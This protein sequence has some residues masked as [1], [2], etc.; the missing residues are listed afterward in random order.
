[1]KKLLPGQ[2]RFVVRQ[3]NKLFR[4]YDV[5]RASYP[6]QTDELGVV[7]QDV[8]EAEAQ[9]E[10][11]RLEALT[12]PAPS[13]KQAA[14]KRSSKT[15]QLEEVEVDDAAGAATADLEEFEVE[16]YEMSEDQK[17]KHEEEVLSGKY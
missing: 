14:G 6:Y 9:A 15:V 8:S 5:A 4:V 13:K 10:A 1:M 7:V 11:D 2:L 12:K 16:E 3:I 17:K